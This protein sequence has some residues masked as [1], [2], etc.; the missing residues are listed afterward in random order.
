M[1]PLIL[2]LAGVGAAL[3]A[4]TWYAV[5]SAKDGYEDE[6]GFHLAPREK[7][8]LPEGEAH[9]AEPVTAKESPRIP[10]CAPVR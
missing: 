5:V 8:R 3:V 6:T 2:I 4:V 10:P 7:Q 9:V 1:Y